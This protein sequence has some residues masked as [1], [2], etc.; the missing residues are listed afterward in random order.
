MVT[1]SLAPLDPSELL[2]SSFD[3]KTYRLKLSDERNTIEM[4]SAPM[5][6]FQSKVRTPIAQW[7]Q[8][9]SLASMEGGH[10]AGLA[11]GV[12]KPPTFHV[13]DW[14]GPRVASF[15]AAYA[16]AAKANAKAAT[17]LAASK[18]SFTIR[19]FPP[20]EVILSQL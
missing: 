18:R 15:S 7:S 4:L 1:D 17:L 3:L 9:T 16:G 14:P 8:R 13:K 10:A 11:V 5:F 19:A 6:L 12:L 20:S 2:T